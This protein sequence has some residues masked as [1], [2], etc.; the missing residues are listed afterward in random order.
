MISVNIFGVIGSKGYQVYPNMQDESYFQYYNNSEKDW[1]LLVRC[2]NNVVRYIY[3]QYDLKSAL[4]GTSQVRGGM[5]LGIAIEMEG[6]YIDSVN[7]NLIPLLEEAFE[8][9]VEQQKLVK[10][11][12]NK[13]HFIPDLLIRVKPALDAYI[14]GITET[15]TKDLKEHLRS[16]PPSIKPNSTKQGILSNEDTDDYVNSIFQNY[17]ALTIKKG[18]EVNSFKEADFGINEVKFKILEAK[19]KENEEIAKVLEAK[20]RE[21]EAKLKKQSQSTEKG[22]KNVNIL[23]ETEYNKLKDEVK[24]TKKI[25]DDRKVKRDEF[26]KTLKDDEIKFRKKQNKEREIF[27][28]SIS[29][30][31]EEEKDIKISDYED[32]QY[33]IELDN[34]YNIKAQ[35]KQ[36]EINDRNDKKI[37]ESEI[38]FKK[39]QIKAYEDSL[40]KG[41]IGSVPLKK[42]LIFS[43]TA[44]ALLILGFLFYVKTTTQVETKLV[45]KRDTIYLKEKKIATKEKQENIKKETTPPTQKEIEYQINKFIGNN[46]NQFTRAI[47]YLEKNKMHVN[48][49]WYNEEMMELKK[50]RINELNSQI[51]NYTNN[52]KYNLSKTDNFK[53]KASTA[54]CPNETLQLLTLHSKDQVNLDNYLGRVEMSED[55]NNIQTIKKPTFN[56]QFYKKLDLDKLCKELKKSQ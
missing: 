32:K 29:N 26:E 22:D 11:I 23:S 41:L 19:N 55:K 13:V 51:I 47:D 46:N 54:K 49:N 37:F 56:T 50:A 53:E 17:G 36:F 34:E 16:I 44:L 21:L 33:F 1:A 8:E 52:E 42:V 27:I 31:N 35:K 45:T 12:N 7:E 5:V 2:R 39:A 43:G 28:S 38:N 15:L 9:M 6:M 14:K 10:K 4:P 18:V 48:S 40:S 24:N 3:L 25:E 20:I 30:L